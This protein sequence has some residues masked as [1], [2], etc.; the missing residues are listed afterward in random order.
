MVLTWLHIRITW[1][2]FLKTTDSLTQ[3]QTSKSDSVENKVW[4]TA[5]QV[6]CCAARVGNHSYLVPNFDP[7]GD[8]DLDHLCQGSPS[9]I[10]CV[11][12]ISWIGVKLMITGHGL[13]FEFRQKLIFDFRV[14]VLERK[15]MYF[16][17]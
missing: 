13:H 1:D 8:P 10:T 5:P 4:A 12:S 14:V 16:L 2:A 9:T 3:R 11:G 6:S 17:I 7:H 15:R